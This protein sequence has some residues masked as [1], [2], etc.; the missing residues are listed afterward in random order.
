MTLLL[1]GLRIALVVYVAA[2][3]ALYVLQDRLLLPPVQNVTD[4]RPG[5]HADYDVQPWYPRDEY[6]GYLIAPAGREPIGT[7]LVYHGNAESAENKQSLAEVFVRFG[8]RVV[9]VEYPGYGKRQGARTMK[10]ALAASRS[11]LSDAKA[12]WAGTIF[13]L[14]ESLGAGMAA[15]AIAGEES[16]VAGV[17]LVTPWDSL[18][19]VASEKLRLFPVG[20]ILHNPF[21]TVDA[22]K[23]YAGQ[24]VVV[25]CEKDTL[26]PVSHAERLTRLHPHAQ[27]LLLPGAGHDDWFGLMTADRWQQVLVWLQR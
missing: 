4:I 10:A 18:E 16:A 21:D 27:F 3:V 23:H 20:W 19:S 6:A 11:A 1:S 15:K 24:V 5:H 14:G 13:L 8:Y 9:L 26:I 2:V 7:L 22:L 17:L 12:Q 25:G